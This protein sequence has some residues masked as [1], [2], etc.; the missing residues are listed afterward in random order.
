MPPR[1]DYFNARRRKAQA[2]SG[3]RGGAGLCHAR[4][5]FD[6]DP[7]LRIFITCS[8]D[9]QQ[10]CCYRREIQG[11]AEA[12]ARR[13]RSVAAVNPILVTGAA[14]FIGFHVARRLVEAGREVI[15]VDNLSPYYDPKL[16][17]GAA[18]AARRRQ[19]FQVR[20]AGSGGPRRH[21]G[22]VRRA[23]LSVRHPS[24]R[25]S[26]RAAFAGRPVCLCGRQSRRLPQHPRRLPPP[27]LPASA[28]MH[29]RRRSTAPIP[30]CRSA[31]PTTSIIRS[32]STAPRKRRTS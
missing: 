4:F 7:S 20:A 17:A 3:N 11:S 31:P 15:G 2:S 28:S 16:E 9:L 18:A 23:P 25:A 27:R 19:E 13:H 12:K 1:Q 29:R 26:R 10:S 8:S 32:A 30:R 5:L 22:A 21:R 14:G 6:P 24:R